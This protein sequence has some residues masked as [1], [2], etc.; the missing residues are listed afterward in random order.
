MGFEHEGLPSCGSFLRAHERFL[1]MFTSYL[2][3]M[4]LREWEIYQ[5][6]VVCMGSEWLRSFI[7]MS[8]Y[9]LVY[10]GSWLEHHNDT[11]MLY[12]DRKNMCFPIDVLQKQYV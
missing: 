9:H 3:C 1:E 11:S 6:L 8:Q 2:P 5:E 7:N 4:R 10:D 12:N